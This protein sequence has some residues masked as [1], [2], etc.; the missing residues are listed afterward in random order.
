MIWLSA[1]LN[2][3]L[4]E[5]QTLYSHTQSKCLMLLLGICR[6][7]CAHKGSTTQD[8]KCVEGWGLLCLFSFSYAS[9]PFLGWY[10]LHM[11]IFNSWGET[12]YKI[13]SIYKSNELSRPCVTSPSIHIKSGYPTAVNIPVLWAFPPWPLA[14]QVGFS[15]LFPRNSP[16][17]YLVFSVLHSWC[18]V[19]ILSPCLIHTLLFIFTYYSTTKRGKFCGFW[20]DVL[21]NA[22]E[23][24]N[25]TYFS[26][27]VLI[28]FS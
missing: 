14:S 28:Y 7:V 6:Y 26:K 8:R 9:I 2:L 16:C 5:L 17:P 23:I 21:L 12:F 13:G 20:R 27:P 25:P 24:Q 11:L 1:A 19:T 3:D 10:L 4:T 15:Q 22:K 18:F